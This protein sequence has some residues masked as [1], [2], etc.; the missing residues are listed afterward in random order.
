MIN[1]IGPLFGVSIIHENGN[2]EYNSSNDYKVTHNKLVYEKCQ[3]EI[4]EISHYDKMMLENNNV[5][6]LWSNAAIMTKFYDCIVVIESFEYKVAIC[7]IPEVV[8]SEQLFAFKKMYS[9]ISYN[10]FHYGDRTLIDNKFKIKSI[11]DQPLE[12]ILNIMEE[13]QELKRRYA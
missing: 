2:L 10:E 9:R 5:V 7:F 11:K 1:N 6:G 3:K 12:Y 13:K 4:D 8:T